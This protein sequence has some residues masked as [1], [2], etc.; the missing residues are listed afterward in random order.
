MDGSRFHEYLCSIILQRNIKLA[1]ILRIKYLLEIRAGKIGRS[2]SFSIRLEK[3]EFWNCTSWLASKA[4]MSNGELE[5][6]IGGYATGCE[7]LHW[8]IIVEVSSYKKDFR[9]RRQ[10]LTH[11][12]RLTNSTAI[13]T[14]WLVTI[15]GSIF[16][17]LL[18]IDANRKIAEGNE[19]KKSWAAASK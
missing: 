8:P 16:A 13:V 17:W 18:V 3:R 7:I 9:D 10:Y 12:S 2:S 14:I 11:L 1:A 4:S 19:R 5:L 15:T 6:A